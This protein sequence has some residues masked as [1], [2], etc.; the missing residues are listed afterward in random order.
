MPLLTCFSSYMAAIPV[1]AWTV[2][3][4]P[5][6]SP[7][8]TTLKV[9]EC[10]PLPVCGNP[11]SLP[12]SLCLVFTIYKS[13]RCQMVPSLF[14]CS[15]ESSHASGPQ[16]RGQRHT[17]DV[18]IYYVHLGHSILVM[19]FQTRVNPSSDTAL[20]TWVNAWT[21]LSYSLLI[22]EMRMIQ[23]PHGLIVRH[24]WLK[25]GSSQYRWHTWNNKHSLLQHSENGS[26]E[27]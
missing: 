20:S 15:L 6:L 21:C 17:P 7:L 3:Q 26:L 2:L 18:P 16:C 23:L 5:L 1:W 4:W 25:V 13:T 14:Q 10:S 24:E 8:H 19:C 9:T 11:N 12:R 27:I 22:C